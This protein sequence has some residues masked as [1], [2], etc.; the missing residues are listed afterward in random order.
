MEYFEDLAELIEE[1]REESFEDFLKRLDELD[2]EDSSEIIENYMDEIQNAL[3]DE[4]QGIY[5]LIENIKTGLIF[6]SQNLED[7]RT[8]VKFAEELYRFREWYHDP[9][10]IRIDGREASVFDAVINERADK[11]LNGKSVYDFEKALDYELH[12]FEMSIG[13]FDRID[14]VGDKTDTRHVH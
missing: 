9:K 1:E 6:L 3:P 14:I 8:R 7:Y 11:L 10:L 12:D 5:M 4:E 13:S 2:P